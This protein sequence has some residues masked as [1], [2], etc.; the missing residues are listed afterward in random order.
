MMNRNTWFITTG[1]ASRGSHFLA[2]G[3]SSKEA[4][5]L[6]FAFLL[7]LSKRVLEL[8]EFLDLRLALSCF[9]I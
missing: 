9:Y 4:I 8:G 3:L 7:F 5:S 2:A 6:L 1:L